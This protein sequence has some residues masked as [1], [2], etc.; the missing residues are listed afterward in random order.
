MSWH[1]L[2]REAATAAKLGVDAIRRVRLADDA[3]DADTS[4]SS[5]RGLLLRP[6]DQALRDFATHNEALRRLS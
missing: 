2:A 1:E 3:E 6:L 4:L 5:R